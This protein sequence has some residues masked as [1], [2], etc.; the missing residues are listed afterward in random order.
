MFFFFEEGRGGK[1]VMPV[2]GK[3]LNTVLGPP[4]ARR[5]AAAVRIR[6]FVFTRI[7]CVLRV[8]AV[9]LYHV[10]GEKKR[11]SRTVPYRKCIRIGVV[12]S[13]AETEARLTT[14]VP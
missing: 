11:T 14:R 6:V 2:A 9:R 3:S 8:Y 13:G 1:V 10:F 5:I 12:H 4:Q 7:E